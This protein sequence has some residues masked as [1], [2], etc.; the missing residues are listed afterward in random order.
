MI[1]FMQ[2]AFHT[3]VTPFIC[4]QYHPSFFDLSFRLL[5]SYPTHVLA[6]SLAA[7]S[8]HLYPHVPHPVTEV[9]SCLRWL[10][11]LTVLSSANVKDWEPDHMT[12]SPSFLSL[13]YFV[14]IF[15]L[16]FMYNNRINRV[17]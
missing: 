7:G 5:R 6:L 4:F 13:D 8:S 9:N 15:Q 14:L 3:T 17:V 1:V 12:P 11:R 2:N 10:N 16:T